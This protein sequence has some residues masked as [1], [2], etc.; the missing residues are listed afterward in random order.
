ML[1]LWWR[2]GQKVDAGAGR[3]TTMSCRGA[4]G[5]EKDLIGRTTPPSKVRI[6]SGGKSLIDSASAR[7]SQKWKQ[8]KAT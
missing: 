8:K 5:R 7:T 6:L 4:L 2:K 3:V 1:T